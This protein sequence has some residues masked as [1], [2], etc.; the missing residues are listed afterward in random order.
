M[1][2]T[3]K[4]KRVPVKRNKKRATN[5][6][7][8][9]GFLNCYLS[10]KDKEVLK[11]SDLAEEYPLWHLAQFVGQQYKFSFSY[12][13][14]TESFVVTMT[15]RDGDSPFYGWALSG[16]GSTVQNAFAALM[17]KH[18]IKWAD[19]WHLNNADRKSLEFD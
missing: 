16:H 19:G 13:D 12:S 1:T 4:K 5:Y 7:S 2:D 3:P 8:W 10:D 11:G 18:R 14:Y 17:Y 15:D 6:D 9:Q